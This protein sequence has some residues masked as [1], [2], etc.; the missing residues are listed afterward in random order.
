VLLGV[1]GIQRSLANWRLSPSLAHLYLS[2]DFTFLVDSLP[3]NLGNPDEYTVKD[4][5]V[6]IKELTGSNSTIR[7]LPATTDDPR[8]RRPDI[9]LAKRVLGWQPRVTVRRGLERTI[10]YF[11]AELARNGKAIESTGP[12]LQSRYKARAE[13]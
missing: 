11:R 3:V 4:F 7:H 5:A 13:G 10:S 8:Q 9:T 1:V 12:V 6:L 2:I